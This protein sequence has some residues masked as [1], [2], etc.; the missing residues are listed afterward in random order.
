MRKIAV[1]A[2]VLFSFAAQADDF[3]LTVESKGNGYS[4]TWEDFQYTYPVSLPDLVYAQFTFDYD[5]I[6]LGAVVKEETRNKKTRVNASGA[7]A[8]AYFRIDA[9][10][11]FLFQV[12]GREPYLARVKV[13]ESNTVILDAAGQP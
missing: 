1:L 6:F 5:V 8:G 4:L 9:Y 12:K 2:L 11:Y 10:D 3:T 13:G 7:T